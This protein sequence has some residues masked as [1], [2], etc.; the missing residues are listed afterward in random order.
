MDSRGSSPTRPTNYSRE[1]PKYDYV[2]GPLTDDELPLLLDD[3]VAEVAVLLEAL[4]HKVLLA[5]DVVL[6]QRVRLHLGVADLQLVH[7]AEQAEHL[8]LLLR[9]HLAGKHLLQA[10][11]PLPLLQEP[12]L[13]ETL[14]GGGGE[15]LMSR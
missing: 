4:H 8:P 15:A 12:P 14:W 9:A 13:Q 7:L 10:P 5:D 6:E 11:R 2:W 3:L 1:A